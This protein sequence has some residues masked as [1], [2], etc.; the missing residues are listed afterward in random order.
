MDQ[1]NRVKLMF[2]RNRRQTS[3]HTQLGQ[4]QWFFELSLRFRRTS[5]GKR[6]LFKRGGE[7][8][9]IPHRRE[10]NGEFADGPMDSSVIRQLPMPV[11]ELSRLFEFVKKETRDFT[12]FSPEILERE[13][14]SL[15]IL[16]KL[17]H[18]GY[19]QLNLQTQTSGYRNQD[20]ALARTKHVDHATATQIIKAVEKLFELNKLV[21][22]V[23]F[24]DFLDSIQ[25]ATDL[26]HRSTRSFAPI[27][28]LSVEEF[29]TLFSIVQKYTS[30][31]TEFPPA[32]LRKYPQAILVFRIILNAP[33]SVF[34]A[35]LDAK[36]HSVIVIEKIENG[37]K[38][39]RRHE[40]AAK[41]AESIQRI[42]HALDLIGKVDANSVLNNFNTIKGFRNIW[43]HVSIS[44]YAT[45]ASHVSQWTEKTIT[46]Q[47]A[48]IIEMLERSGINCYMANK[49]RPQ[50]PCCMVHPRLWDGYRWKSADFA[51][52][53][54]CNPV[55][56]IECRQ[57]DL[58]TGARF[59]EEVENVFRR[60][61]RYYGSA[62]F[63]IAVQGSHY[64][65]IFEPDFVE[66]ADTV[67]VDTNIEDLP[68]YL[69]S[70]LNV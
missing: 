16:M 48:R 67:F 1:S 30:N 37:E 58:P 4:V 43:K 11:N 42:F 2:P 70:L 59:V 68:E 31:F 52:P 40:T 9:T 8:M 69:K 45:Q 34:A 51:A 33:R 29:R 15:W 63:V 12:V 5:I 21:G 46:R 24:S 66:I 49:P 10:G 47:E 56:I 55:A 41:Y 35:I 25:D 23:T 14:R 53:D 20:I 7:Y 22:N 27:T 6:N 3:F 36:N 61:K 38:P 64:P 26:T 39:I 65:N 62:K 19:K 60:M 54:N 28:Q 18:I 17:L 57:V 32:L 13:P 50:D 44:D